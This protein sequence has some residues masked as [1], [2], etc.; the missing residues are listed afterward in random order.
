MIELVYLYT[1]NKGEK[2]EDGTVPFHPTQ[3]LSLI[4]SALCYILSIWVKVINYFFEN[5]SIVSMIG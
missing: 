5:L 4:K 2:R 3:Q 1:I